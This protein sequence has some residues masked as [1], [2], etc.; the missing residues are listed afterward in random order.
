MTEEQE[1]IAA[2]EQLKEEKPELIAQFWKS[3]S[4]R[5]AEEFP[6]LNA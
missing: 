1:L 5:S 6:R 3:S 2:Y 4:S